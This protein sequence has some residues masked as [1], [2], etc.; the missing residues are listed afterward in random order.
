MRTSTPTTMKDD[1]TQPTGQMVVLLY[2]ELR[3]LAASRILNEPSRITLQATDLVHE[4]FVRLQADDHSEWQSRAHFFAAAAEAM[5][6][7]LIERARRKRAVIHGGGHQRVELNF[8]IACPLGG[9]QQCDEIDLAEALDQF[10]QEH[11]PK[12]ELIKLVHYA[13]LTIKEAAEL[14]GV[15]ERTG[16]TYY[17]YGKA[18]L[19]AA[20]NAN[21]RPD[22]LAGHAPDGPEEP[23]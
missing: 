16:K 21:A 12:A 9:L 19:V 15:S 11:S 18:W 22:T 2:E 5:R 17:R 6:R 4:V 3:K 10:A 20:L 1:D 23:A 8:E 7:I 13:G 14:I